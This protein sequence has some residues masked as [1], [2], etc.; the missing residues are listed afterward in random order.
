M[1]TSYLM[2]PRNKSGII[3]KNLFETKNSS[4]FVPNKRK[5]G[6]YRYLEIQ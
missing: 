1:I 6:N 3:V 5:Y 2:S 4:I